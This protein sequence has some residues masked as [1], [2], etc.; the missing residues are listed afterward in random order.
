MP[1]ELDDLNLRARISPV[2]TDRLRLTLVFPCDRSYPERVRA[3]LADLIRP[4][5]PTPTAGTR[6][7]AAA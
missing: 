7:A 2:G 4:P 3:A 1:L 5:D 6:E